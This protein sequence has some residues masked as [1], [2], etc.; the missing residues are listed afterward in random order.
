M[1]MVRPGD[2][3]RESAGFDFYREQIQNRNFDRLY[4]ARDEGGI[5]FNLTESY[6]FCCFSTQRFLRKKP[7]PVR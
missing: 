3:S 2:G 5:E 4:I 1:V 6:V 7:L